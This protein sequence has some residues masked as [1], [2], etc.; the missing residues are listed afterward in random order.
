MVT[1]SACR[2]RVSAESV[3]LPNK[4]DSDG[5]VVA[6]ELAARRDKTVQ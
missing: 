3:R 6:F 1:T 2:V 4:F 5:R